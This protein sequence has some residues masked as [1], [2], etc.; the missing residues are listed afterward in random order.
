MDVAENINHVAQP[1]DNIFLKLFCTSRA[2]IGHTRHLLLDSVEQLQKTLC[3]VKPSRKQLGSKGHCSVFAGD[4]HLG[5]NVINNI[6]AGDLNAISTSH[7][8][9]V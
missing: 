9:Y 6:I 8:F 4:S 3:E 7:E 2:K 5:S 1:K